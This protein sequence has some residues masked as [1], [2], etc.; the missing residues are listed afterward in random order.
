M[1]ICYKGVCGT[2][3]NYEWDER[4]PNV[5]SLTSFNISCDQ[6]RTIL[7]LQ[8]DKLQ[9]GLCNYDSGTHTASCI[10]ASRPTYPSVTPKSQLVKSSTSVTPTTRPVKSS[11]TVHASSVSTN[12]PSHSLRE[13]TTVSTHTHVHVVIVQLYYVLH[14]AEGNDSSPTAFTVHLA[15]ALLAVVAVVISITAVVIVTVKKRKRSVR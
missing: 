2:A 8:S 10:R 11:T 5:A 4:D 1:E 7:P 15:G 14:Q 13:T 3:C 12:I 9:F 6:I